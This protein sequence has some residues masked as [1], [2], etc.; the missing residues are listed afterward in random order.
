[1]KSSH[2]ALAAG[3]VLAG[4]FIQD[5]A[6]AQA[7][8]DPATFLGG[9]VAAPAPPRPGDAMLSCVQIAREMETLMRARK[10]RVEGDGVP[11]ARCSSAGPAAPQGVPTTAKMAQVG[12]ALRGM[13]D[14]R[15]LRLALLAEDRNCANLG[16]EP[17]P[18]PEE[19]CANGSEGDG[20]A[21]DG[22]TQ[23]DPFKRA[24]PTVVSTRPAPFHDARP[25]GATPASAPAAADTD[26]FRRR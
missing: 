11:A 2:P 22:A 15:L 26:P 6:S 19:G 21:G 24:K 14:P 3:L 18:E 23:P 25:D 17:E 13:N 10:V 9:G 8:P 4:G 12:G 5:F 7:L 1:M 16:P 20:G